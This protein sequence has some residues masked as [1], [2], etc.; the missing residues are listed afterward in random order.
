MNYFNQ[1]LLSPK[2]LSQVIQFEALCFGEKGE[3]RVAPG[4]WRSKAWMEVWH[5]GGFAGLESNLALLDRTV[6][7]ATEYCS[8][9]WIESKIAFLPPDFSWEVNYCPRLHSSCIVIFIYKQ[10]I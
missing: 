2:H 7:G 5:P 6:Q 9:H 4:R 10:N 3:E 8:F 1:L